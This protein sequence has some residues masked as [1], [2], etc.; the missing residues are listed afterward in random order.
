MHLILKWGSVC[1]SQW[2]NNILKFF[3]CLI[4][5]FALVACSN[6][7][8]TETGQKSG[9][10]PFEYCNTM[11]FA[12]DSAEYQQCVNNR[13]HDICTERGIT[14]GTDAFGQCDTNLRKATFV[15]QQLQI[16]GF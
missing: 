1:P 7:P 2:E 12:D 6:S 13:I 5:L 9:N 8:E 14:P 10:N 11:G 3:I 16:R 15:R 4:V